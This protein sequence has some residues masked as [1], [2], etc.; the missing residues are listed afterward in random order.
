[1]AYVATIGAPQK[2]DQ[3][4]GTHGGG[5]FE[6]KQKK[7]VAAKA[8]AVTESGW[9]RK[10]LALQKEG[11]ADVGGHYGRVGL[12]FPKKCPRPG[13]KGSASICL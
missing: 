7:R 4:T 8:A 9:Q 1:V 13:T 10:R 12:I 5:S 11:S 6:R 3:N 2:G